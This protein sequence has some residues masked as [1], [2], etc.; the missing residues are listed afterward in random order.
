MFKLVIFNFLYFNGIS[1]VVYVLFFISIKI[2]L[3]N[4]SVFLI[5]YI[6]I[7]FEIYF[8]V[9]FIELCFFYK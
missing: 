8:S 1:F 3:G 5:L 4:L 7:I 2:G 9:F 6:V